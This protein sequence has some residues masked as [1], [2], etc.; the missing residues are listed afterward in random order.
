[1]ELQLEAKIEPEL[2]RLRHRFI[3]WMR[4]AEITKLAI[5]Y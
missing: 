3:R 1:V 4:H 2:N 5:T